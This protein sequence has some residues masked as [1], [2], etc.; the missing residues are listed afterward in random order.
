MKK[1]ETESGT[2]KVTFNL[3]TALVK[4]AKHYAVDSDQTLQAVVTEA[5]TLLLDR[6]GVAK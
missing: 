5:L 6:K 3:S 2:V 4:R 1:R